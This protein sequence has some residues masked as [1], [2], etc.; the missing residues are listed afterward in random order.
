MKR[1]SLFGVPN[2]QKNRKLR[3]P[4]LTDEELEM[5]LDNIF[6]QYPDFT[7]NPVAKIATI[8]N[9]LEDR[10]KQ[11][12]RGKPKENPKPKSEEVGTDYDEFSTPLEV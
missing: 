8:C 5:N 6:T 2:F 9:M 12:I 1:I 10:N 7:Y 3:F 11:K 4:D